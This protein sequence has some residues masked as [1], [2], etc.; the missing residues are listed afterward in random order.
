MVVIVKIAT[1]NSLEMVFV[2][3]NDMIQTLSANA[4]DD[5]LDV[6]IL[7]RASRCHGT[8]F[9]AQTANAFSKVMAIDG[10]AITQ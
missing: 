10:I 6:G 5:A 1:E 8:L 9:D 3:N 4:A 7:P 2:E